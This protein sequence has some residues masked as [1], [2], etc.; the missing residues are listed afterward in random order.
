MYQDNVSHLLLI[1]AAIGPALAQDPFTVA[2]KNY[3]MEFENEW[4]RVSRAMFFPG[5]KLPVHDHPANP[6]VFVYLTNG[7]SIRFTHI[8]PVFTVERQPV[9]AGAIRFHT[10]ATETHVAEYLGKSAT[11]YL[12]IELKTERPDRTRQHIRIAA[13]DEKPFENGQLRIS[14]SQCPANQDGAGSAYPAAIVSMND[15]SVS[16]QEAGKR[17]TNPKD[18]TVRQIR[19]ELKTN[20]ALSKR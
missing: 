7:G 3:R 19:V 11:E 6:T 9:K 18:E 20:P 2:P 1:L 14:R 16:W 8:Q 4:V 5:D 12:R 15:R 13:D 10:G 17:I